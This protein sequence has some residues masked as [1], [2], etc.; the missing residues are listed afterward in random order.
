MPWTTICD[1]DELQNRVGK[2]VDIDGY[3][4]AVFK[5]DDAVHVIDRICPHAGADLS[6]GPVTDGCVVCPRHYW[7]F[8]LSDGQYCDSPGFAI[9][10]YSCRVHPF[11][12]RQL[13]QAEL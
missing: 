1:L 13:V 9:D 12:G 11:H 7:A 3:Q 5:V 4:L 8:R 2:P 6:A 10:T